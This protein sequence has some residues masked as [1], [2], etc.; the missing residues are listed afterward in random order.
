MYSSGIQDHGQ[1]N[2]SNTNSVF[3]KFVRTLMIVLSLFP[4]GM[5]PKGP[6][7]KWNFVPTLE[8]LYSLRLGHVC[9]VSPNRSYTNWCW[10]ALNF[11]F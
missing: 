1:P 6:A 8:E 7:S 5:S 3:I 10:I 11:H 9:S 4:V 2:S